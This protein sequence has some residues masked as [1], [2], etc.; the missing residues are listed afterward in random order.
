MSSGKKIFHSI[1]NIVIHWYRNLS[2]LYLIAAAY[3]WTHL[4]L[5]LLLLL[6]LYYYYYYIFIFIFHY[7]W[8][9]RSSLVMVLG[10]KYE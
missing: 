8:Y 1:F 3:F 4:L 2:C 9:N 6:L 7:V 5:L 10:P